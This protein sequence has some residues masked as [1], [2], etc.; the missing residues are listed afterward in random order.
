MRSYYVIL[1]AIGAYFNG[2]PFYNGLTFHRV[3][4][5]FMIQ[6]GCTIGDGTVGAKYS[7]DDE[8]YDFTNSKTISGMIHRSEIAQHLFGKIILPYLQKEKDPTRKSPV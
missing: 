3:I 2:N 4:N 6:G 1:L 7:F 8:S 5:D